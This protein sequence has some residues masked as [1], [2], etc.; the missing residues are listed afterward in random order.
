MTQKA[1]FEKICN[2]KLSEVVRNKAQERLLE[3]QAEPLGYIC[4][5][6]RMT[7]LPLP[8]LLICEL[9]CMLCLRTYFCIHHTDFFRWSTFISDHLVVTYAR[10]VDWTARVGR[11]GSALLNGL[12]EAAECV[13]V[14]NSPC[15]LRWAP[16][17]LRGNTWF[18]VCRKFDLLTELICFLSL[19]GTLAPESFA[20]S[21]ERT[22]LAAVVTTINT[23]V[24]IGPSSSCI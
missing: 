22:I 3:L 6:H 18:L 12:L 1:E 21:S 5:T 2:E 9:L 13:L 10:D 15:W 20:T 14:C 7:P 24:S 16:L 23:R 19:H 11:Q 4:L 17:L 8:C